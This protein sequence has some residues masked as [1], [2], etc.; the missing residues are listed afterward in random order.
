MTAPKA[1]PAVTGVA[2]RNLDAALYQVR[3]LR[4]TSCDRNGLLRFELAVLSINVQPRYTALSYGWG[5]ASTKERICINGQDALVP[6]NLVSA[7]RNLG[8]KEG[9]LLWADA[10]CINQEN[11]PE[12]A[13]QVKLMGL[14]YEKAYRVVIWLGSEGEDTAHATALLG[15][16][17]NHVNFRKLEEDGYAYHDQLAAEVTAPRFFSDPDFAHHWFAHILQ[18]QKDPA[19]ALRGVNEIVMRPYWERVWVVQEAAKA[20]RALVRCGR[21]RINLN[22]ILAIVSCLPGIPH[23]E[24]TLLETILKFRIQESNS[25]GDC[26]NRVSLY[27]AL[28]DTR[29]SLATE[30]RDK[31]Y[32]L[33]GLTSDGDD[34]LPTPS[35]VGTPEQAFATVSRAIL[36]SRRATNLLLLSGWV[37]LNGKD[38]RPQVR[39]VDWADTKFR[40]PNWL[41]FSFGATTPTVP[42]QVVDLPDALQTNGCE[43]ATINGLVSEDRHSISSTGWSIGSI[44]SSGT[45]TAGEIDGTPEEVV[46]ELCLDLLQR[47][48]QDQPLSEVV[49]HKQLTDAFARIIRDV[50]Q[51][52]PTTALRYGRL[53]YALETL[54]EVM[55]GQFPIWEW[56]RRYNM[57][58]RYQ[59]TRQIIPDIQSGSRKARLLSTLCCC[60]APK[61]LEMEDPDPNPRVPVSRE[62]RKNL[63]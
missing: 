54:A 21:L 19:R 2:Y 6:T 53:R 32:S 16:F 39:A 17:A 33:L 63:T 26:S 28:I 35:Y 42:W 36:R 62:S 61:D 7:L 40:I 57:A 23:R 59:A 9:D 12:K 45:V 8:A 18:K 37:P 27:Q 5:D 24:Q 1:K 52:K 56:A 49:S 11:K 46:N 30:P 4:Y 60:S 38:I 44:D 43:I 29:Y 58:R 15:D 14:I 51:G 34:L 22:A 3:F 47:F 41:T 13:D 20:S 25:A 31:V 50:N 10:V 55:L 48:Q